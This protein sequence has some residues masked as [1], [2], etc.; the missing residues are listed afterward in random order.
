MKLLPIIL[1]ALLASNLAFAAPKKTPEKKSSEPTATTP[2]PAQQPQSE[3]GAQFIITAESGSLRILDETQGSFSLTLDNVAK[4]VLNFNAKQKSQ[5]SNTATRD[6]VD[7]WIKLGA[8]NTKIPP[9]AAIIFHTINDSQQTIRLVE[10]SNPQF[11]IHNSR[12][13]FVVKAIDGQ[14]IDIRA[15]LISPII[16]GVIFNS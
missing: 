14:S 4:D 6:F 5:S 15:A 16:T 10:L 7:Q 13:I 9:S 12:L 3:N 1:V 8:T 11:D 2:A